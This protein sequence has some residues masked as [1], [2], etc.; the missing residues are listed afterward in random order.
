MAG[1]SKFANI[2]HRKEKNDQAKAKIFTKLGK[3]II[4][5]CKSGG[6]DPTTNSRLRDA[7]YKAKSNN[8]PNDNIDRLLKKASGEANSDNFENITYEGYGPNGVAVIVTTLTD[9]RNRTAG[10]VRNAF[11]KGGG[12]MGTTGSVSF[13][14]TEKGYVH[15]LKE[16]CE[17]DVL[18]DLALNNGASDFEVF[19]EYY[20]ITTE[21]FE[22]SNV[23]EALENAK[24]EVFANEVGFFP[25]TH[26]K[27]TSAE[28]IKKMN[29]LLTLLEDDD[30]VQDVYHNLD[31]E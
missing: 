8:M 23:L 31:E 9:N 15:V 28:D 27:L 14:F 2:K 18:M 3:E 26:V 10:N 24:I 13:L 22:H 12:N 7:I 4:V 30:D 29:K 1:H 5:A 11:T 25:E 21:V 6:A 17:E 16:A 20:E 19:D